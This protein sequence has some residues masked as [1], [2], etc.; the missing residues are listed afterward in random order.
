M[1]GFTAAAGKQGT[2]GG[3]TTLLTPQT[4]DQLLHS[5]SNTKQQLNFTSQLSPP[6]YEMLSGCPL[7]TAAHFNSKYFFLFPKMPLSSYY[8]L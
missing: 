5:Y 4:K 7:I 2:R 6:S 1:D 3:R 8:L